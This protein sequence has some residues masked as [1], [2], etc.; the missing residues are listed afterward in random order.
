MS[1]VFP[2]LNV[3]IWCFGHFILLFTLHVAKDG[4]HSLNKVHWLG[5]VIVTIRAFYA[6]VSICKIKIKIDGSYFHNWA[7]RAAIWKR[8]REMPWQTDFGWNR[9]TIRGLYMRLPKLP[10]AVCSPKVD[11]PQLQDWMTI[12]GQTHPELR[13]SNTGKKYVRKR[14]HTTPMPSG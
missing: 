8:C 11:P 5:E 2:G 12:Q 3:K 14:R 4:W 1:D 10:N 9:S 7:L 6:N 13:L